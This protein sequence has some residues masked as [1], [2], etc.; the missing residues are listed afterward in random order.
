MMNRGECFSRESGDE[1]SDRPANSRG[2][3]TSGSPFP[4]PLRPVDLRVQFDRTCHSHTYVQRGSNAGKPC[5]GIFAALVYPCF[6]LGEIPDD[7]AGRKIDAAEKFS[8]ALHFV[9]R[10]VSQGYD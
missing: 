6:D 4:L 7:A 3:V 9:N 1:T 2:V 10:G 5:L 8:T